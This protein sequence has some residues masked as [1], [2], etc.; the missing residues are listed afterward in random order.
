MS[1]ILQEQ[2]LSMYFL[3][4]NESHF[5][6]IF[7]CVLCV[8]VCM[9]LIVH[10]KKQPILPL[11][12]DLFHV[13][14]I[15]PLLSWRAPGL[16]IS[17]IWKVNVFIDLLSRCLIWSVF[18]FFSSPGCLLNSLISL[19]FTAHLLLR[20]FVLYIPH[21]HTLISCPWHLYIYR[22]PVAMMS[23]PRFFSIQA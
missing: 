18:G 15:F 21:L 11:F 22:S 4:F 7:F 13:L 9:C 8:F 19:R 10:L 14:T 20:G 5:L 16:G 6:V 23:L 17:T 12:A 1:A 3:L 2:F